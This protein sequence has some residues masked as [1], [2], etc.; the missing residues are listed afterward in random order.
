MSRRLGANNIV[1][2][3]GQDQDSEFQ[4][5]K[6]QV[7]MVGKKRSWRCGCNDAAVAALLCVCVSVCRKKAQLEVRL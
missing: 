6:T 7:L 3:A 5:T 2:G 1:S 4:T